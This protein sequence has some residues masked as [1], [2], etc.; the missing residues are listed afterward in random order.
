M[1]SGEP[2]VQPSQD[3]IR[4]YNEWVKRYPK[5]L[6]CDRDIVISAVRGDGFCSIWAFLVALSFMGREPATFA[7]STVDIQGEDPIHLNDDI[8]NPRSLADVKTLVVF[9]AQE[10]LGRLDRLVH[11]VKGEKVPSMWI[12]GICFSRNDLEVLI[13]ELVRDPETVNSVA[14]IGHIKVLLLITHTRMELY[15]SRNKKLTLSGHPDDLPIYL[16]TNHIHYEVHQPPY[17][18]KISDMMANNLWI[19]E[20]LKGS[21]FKGPFE[22]RAEGVENEVSPQP[23]AEVA[24]ARGVADSSGWAC[25]V[26]TTYNWL[27]TPTCHVCDAPHPLVLYPDVQPPVGVASWAAS[28]AAS[29]AAS[30]AHALFTV[31]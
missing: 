12:N 10:L 9:V 22:L 19:Q 11:P 5:L 24:P 3:E 18:E 6:L 21:P 4:W 30:C 23:V 26:C 14:G 25:L 17:V 8:R 29:W 28:R 1:D 27:G 13:F 7:D 15:D 16:T 20:E 2:A 31:R